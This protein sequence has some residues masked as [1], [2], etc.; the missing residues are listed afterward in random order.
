MS[1]FPPCFEHDQSET[2]AVE[3]FYGNIIPAMHMTAALMNYSLDIVW[4]YFSLQA[5]IDIFILRWFMLV[6]LL[7]SIVVLSTELR[8]RKNEVERQLRA[9]VGDVRDSYVRFVHDELRPPL[10]A[11]HVG[12][13]LMKANSATVSQSSTTL[14]P[15]HPFSARTKHG[16]KYHNKHH[17]NHKNNYNTNNDDDEEEEEEDDDDEE[18]EEGEEEEEEEEEEEGKDRGVARL[19]QIYVACTKVRA[20]THPH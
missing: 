19:S 1:G 3:E 14:S 4:Y 5:T 7:E 9:L 13:A 20:N 6:F 16:N 12:L 2:R 11:M 8:V 18:E 17:N 15:F 10:H